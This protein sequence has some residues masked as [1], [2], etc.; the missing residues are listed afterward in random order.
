M[1]EVALE[2]VCKRYDGVV[3]VHGVHLRVAPGQFVTLLVTLLAPSRCGKTTCLRMVAAFV[4]P[5]MG[6]V[7]IGG[8]D[9]TRTPLYRRNAGMEA[10]ARRVSSQTR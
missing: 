9:V 7:L 3:P 2:Q 4:E 10:S 1:T 5:D 8:A 6:G